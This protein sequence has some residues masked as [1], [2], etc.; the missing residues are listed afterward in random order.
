MSTPIAR[1]G[2][3][4]LAM[5]AALIVGFFALAAQ[6]E[7]STLYACVKKNGS[8]HIY[9][10]KPKCKKGESKL[11]WNN[12]G[13][14]GKNG[15]NGVNGTNGTNG[16][17]GPQGLPGPAKLLSFSPLTLENGWTSYPG[18]TSPVSYAVDGF[19]VV[20]LR[21]GI[22]AGTSDP[23]AILP[24]E[25]RP[26]YEIYAISWGFNAL[27]PTFVRID[28]SGAVNVFDDE[29]KLTKIKSFASLEGVT[30]FSH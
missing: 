6:A 9:A 21:G 14:A 29:G 28:V 15:A 30:F 8:A 24:A 27:T 5:G 4:A 25:A 13:P 19:G 10:K 11:T 7:A 1:R 16:K 18:E 2:V 17:E 22:E 26:K 20:H 12:Q 3:L 23:I